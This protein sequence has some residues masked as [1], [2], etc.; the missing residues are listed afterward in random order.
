[1]HVR[2]IA[3]P[4]AHDNGAGNLPQVLAYLFSI[5]SSMVRHIEIIPFLCPTV[6]LLKQDSII[7]GTISCIVEVISSGFMEAAHR[8]IMTGIIAFIIFRMSSGFMFRIIAGIIWPIISLISSGVFPSIQACI[9]DSMI[10]HVSVSGWARIALPPAR[11]D[12][13]AGAHLPASSPLGG[14][15]ICDVQR[16]AREIRL[17]VGFELQT[18]NG[19]SA[20]PFWER[21]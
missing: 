8:S 1:M 9:I 20:R 6:I 2:S 17:P 19:E 16:C 3:F 7:F 13:P 11:D 4:A 12:E 5:S 14:P 10:S 18:W 21:A 15:E